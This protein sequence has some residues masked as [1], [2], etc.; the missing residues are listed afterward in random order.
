MSQSSIKAI[1]DALT[2]GSLDGC[3]PDWCASILASAR[4]EDVEKVRRTL[5]ETATEG[6]AASMLRVMS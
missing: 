5:S 2:G 4:S 3:D 6:E 1:F